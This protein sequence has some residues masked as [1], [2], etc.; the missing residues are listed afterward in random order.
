[1]ATWL[2]LEQTCAELRLPHKIVRRLL[3]KGQL[4]G[5]VDGARR[6]VKNWRI[7]E[8]SEDYIRAL[9]AQESILSGRHAIDLMQ[10]PIIGSVEFAEL[11]DIPQSTLRNL[12][13]NGTLKPWKMGRYSCYTAQQ[14]RDFLLSRERL[15]PRD[16]RVRC[17]ALVHWCLKKLSDN[18]VETLTEAEVHRDDQ[19]EGSLRRIMR[20]REPERS[21]HLNEFWRRFELAQGVAKSIRRLDRD[22]AQKQA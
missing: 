10:F 16:R 22:A 18:P 13:K 9:H 8:P 4:V 2:T 19:M 20:Q 3:R 6:N 1:M 7:L 17:A 12:V 21:K 14:V 5:F 15:E 11:V